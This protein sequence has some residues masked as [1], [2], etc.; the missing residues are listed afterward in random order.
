MIS[1]VTYHNFKAFADQSIPLR[2]LTLFSGLNGTGKSTVLQ[3]FAMLRQSFDAGFLVQGA[4]LL[5][6]ELIELG[7]GRDVAF[8]DASD[9]IVSIALTGRD[10]RGIK[11]I[12]DV[13]AV[14]RKPDAD[15]LWELPPG[16]K[17]PGLWAEL[18]P[19]NAGFQ[20]LRADRIGPAVT[21]PKSQH[22]VHDRKF[23]GSRGEFV[24]HYLL[25]YGDDE[26]SCRKLIRGEKEHSGKL[27]SQVNAWMQDFSPGV[28]IDVKNVP[29]T[30]FVRLEFAYRTSSAAY[31]SSFRATNVGFGLTH[32]LP[33]I[34]ACLASPRGSLVL[35]EN[36]EAQLHPEG[37]VAVGKLLARLAAEGV[38]VLIETHS[39][40]ILN[41]IRVAIRK[42][43]LT[44]DQ[45]AFHFFRRNEEGR[46]VLHSPAVDKNG[47]LSEWPPGFFTQWD[48]TLLELLG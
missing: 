16:R 25:E 4:W 39:D 1:S 40:H 29:M 38:Q 30:D 42:E 17:Q 27:I 36:P 35:I 41:G 15:F 46:V 6:G 44:P 48:D 31:G 24:P 10:R 19:F 47:L 33:V 20:Y 12:S 28:R 7:T 8:D 14:G 18:S 11:T 22:A 34:V 2:A 32:A 45:A 9:E 3:G 26:I 37:Q 5:N 21:F 43:L 23:L 13:S